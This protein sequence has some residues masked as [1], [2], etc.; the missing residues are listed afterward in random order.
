MVESEK[1]LRQ[2]DHWE[3]MKSRGHLT[4]LAINVLAWL[5]VDLGLKAIQF[6]CFKAGWQTSPG[7]SWEDIVVLGVASGVI[8]GEL[9][10]SDMKRKFRIPPPEEDWVAK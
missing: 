1:K 3:R 10:W 2:R 5:G 4:H 6:L 8:G 7:I 9:Y